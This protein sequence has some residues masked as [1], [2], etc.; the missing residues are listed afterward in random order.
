[1]W[2]VPKQRLRWTPTL[3][4][5]MAQRNRE[6]QARFATIAAAQ[7]ASKITLPWDY[8]NIG[9]TDGTATEHA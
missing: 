2:N 5:T 4:Q 9:G 7:V 1:M 6:F 8:P 3:R